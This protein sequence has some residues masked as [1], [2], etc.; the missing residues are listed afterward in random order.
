MKKRGR[1]MCPRC[2]KNEFLVKESC[3]RGTPPRQ[4]HIC[5]SVQKFAQGFN[6]CSLQAGLFSHDLTPPLKRTCESM[7][8]PPR[9]DFRA[10]LL[11]ICLQRRPRPPRRNGSPQIHVDDPQD[12][13]REF[14]SSQ[15]ATLAMNCSGLNFTRSATLKAR[16]NEKMRQKSR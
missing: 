8:F 2:T 7:V 10:R 14:E 5:E 12:H 3:C 15:V 1:I 16:E 4:C 11:H 13:L 9:D 6:S